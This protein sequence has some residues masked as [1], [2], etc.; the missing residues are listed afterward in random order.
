MVSLLQ[1]V[2]Y[3]YE[4]TDLQ[5]FIEMRPEWSRGTRKT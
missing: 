3:A 1:Q 2:R 5:G 4:K